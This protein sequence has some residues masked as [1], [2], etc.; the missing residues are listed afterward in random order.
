[1]GGLHSDMFRYL[2]LLP[3]LVQESSVLRNYKVLGLKSWI[4]RALRK[5]HFIS[6]LTQV[7]S[8]IIWLSLIVVDI[9]EEPSF[10]LTDV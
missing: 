7:H 4:Q 8:R 2:V 9:D 6:S 1:M 3:A 5:S 10:L